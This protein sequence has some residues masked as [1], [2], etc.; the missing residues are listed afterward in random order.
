M[1]VT[2]LSH[3]SQYLM[4]HSYVKLSPDLSP[5]FWNINNQKEEKLLSASYWSANVLVHGI[6]LVL[7]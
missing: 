1:E 2:P 5:Q 4:P 3:S 7:L 6:S